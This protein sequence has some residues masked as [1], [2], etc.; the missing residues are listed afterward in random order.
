MTLAVVAT[1]TLAANAIHLEAASAETQARHKP[2][3]PPHGNQAQ[4]AGHRHGDQAWQ[5]NYKVWMPAHWQRLAACESGSPQENLNFAFRGDYDGAFGF[6]YGTWDS[7]K[8]VRWWPA[9]AWQAT[10]FQQY[11]VARIV[12]AK[13]GIAEPWGC[14][15]GPQHAWVRGGLPEYGVYK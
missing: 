14:W 4:F 9:D 3:G 11:R 12:A 6:A 1:L 10:P 2:D 15:R 7:F 8:P 13:Y 5:W